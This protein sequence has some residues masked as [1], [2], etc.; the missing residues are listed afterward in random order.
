MSH[1]DKL[2]PGGRNAPE[3]GIIAVVN[4]GRDKQGLIPLWAGEGDLPTPEFICEPAISALRAGETFYTWNRGIPELR[5]ALGDYHQRHF[6]R[7]ASPEHHIVTGSGMQAIQLAIQAVSGADDEIVYLS[8]AWPNFAAALGIAGG[9]PVAVELDFKNAWSLDLER[10]ARAVTPRT[11]AIFVNSPS[12]PTGWTAD[13]DTLRQILD[14][15]RANDIWVIADE[16]YALFHYRDGR[17]ASFLDVADDGDRVIYANTF[18][19]NWAMTG[20]RLGW[21]TIHP[22]LQQTFENLVQYSTSGVPQFLQ[23][24]A[25]AAL[26]Q[27]DGFITEQVE[28]AR[29]ARELVCAALDSTGRAAFEKPEGAFYLFFKINGIDDTQAAAF[30]IID[31]AGVGLA[32]GTAFGVGGETFFRIC[33]HRRLDQLEQAMDRLCQWIKAR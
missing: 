31:E 28:R 13:A 2:G 14:I 23:K 15:A 4:H 18:S 6:N 3:S 26:E 22:S 5:T 20:W 8:P 19:K 24:G 29:R 1:I 27:G 10:L 33:F 25:V 21:L 12:N 17:A 16:T 9:R 32:P 7:V 11:R 30:N